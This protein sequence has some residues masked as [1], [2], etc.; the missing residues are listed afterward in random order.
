[1][2]KNLLL[3][4]ALLLTQS[5]SWF[6][7]DYDKLMGPIKKIKIAEKKAGK[8]NPTFDGVIEP[9][10]PDE[11]ENNKTLEGVDSNHDGVRDDIEIWINRT[12]EDEY[13]RIELKEYYQKL[14]AMHAI[15]A[16]PNATDIEK[17]EWESQVREAMTC[18]GV[19]LYPHKQKYLNQRIEIANQYFDRIML[20]VFDT[21]SRS[22]LVA[23]ADA[24]P[25][26]NTREVKS[27]SVGFCSKKIDQNYFL[28][29]IEKYQE[30]RK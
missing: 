24:Y 22:K 29:L 1:M 30:H 23:L 26:R 6:E 12:A 21:N 18:L 8:P 5:C 3:I 17:G 9:D 15:L 10:F 4:L 14:F 16:D 27:G 13:V 20:L 28:N 11:K 7:S 2:L 25:Y 19:A